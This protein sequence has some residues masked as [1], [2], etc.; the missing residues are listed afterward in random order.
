M[1]GLL[2]ESSK[3]F[4]FAEGREDGGTLVIF[5]KLT[6]KIWCLFKEKYNRIKIGLVSIAK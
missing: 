5:V 2:E 4:L 6:V 3:I 1:P